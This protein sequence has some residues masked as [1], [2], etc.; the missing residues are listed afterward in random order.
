[1]SSVAL[2]QNNDSFLMLAETKLS[3][4]TTTLSKF[5]QQTHA[6]E[7][8]RQDAYNAPVEP[9]RARSSRCRSSCV[10]RRA[11]SRPRC[12]RP[13]RA[14]AGA[15]CSSAG[16]SRPRACSS[17]A[18]SSSSRRPATATASLLRPDLVV[19]LPGGR[20]VVVDAK[21]PLAGAA[22]RTRRDARRRRA[23]RADGRL[24]PPRPRPRL[25]AER[26]V[27]LAAVLADARLRRH[28]P[29]G[30][31]LLPRGARARSVAAR[32]PRERARRPREPDDAD[33]APA[34]DRRRL[35]RGDRSPRAHAR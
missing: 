18:T 14:A 13:R 16:R 9:G 5:E 15:R 26:E 6:L 4:L 3:P 28:V 17:T 29:A 22:R 19:K 8:S 20:Q 31:E 35:A 11:A 23:P 33:H 24:R 1:M 10:P 34:R 30:R 27:V 25:E 12:A 7:K 21:T 2:A 32:R